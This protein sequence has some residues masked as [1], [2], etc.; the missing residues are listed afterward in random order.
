M[1]VDCIHFF[2]IWC[3]VSQAGWR[4]RVDGG[5]VAAA[6]KAREEGLI[7]H[8]VVSSHLPG[9]ELA[10]VLKEAPF[11]GVTLGYCAINFPYR[12]KTLDV[13]SRMGL[14]VVTMNPLAGGL[15]PQNAKTFDFIRSE[16][17]ADVVQAAIRFNVSQPA[18]T[19][20]LVG[21]SNKAHVDQ[22]VDAVEH[23]EP[24]PPAHIDAIRQK[25]MTAYN[26]LCTGCG[27]CLP[28]PSGVNIPQLM[29]AYNHKLLREDH[30]D[31]HIVNRLNWH[32]SAKPAAARA[33]SL[34]GACEERCTQRLP[35]RERLKEIAALAEEK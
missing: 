24:Y 35:I 31:E 23:F 19:S 11:E 21:A 18:V 34:C 2:H 3:I 10:G 5:A 14:G 4:E 9:D 27:Y 16:H 17:D 6:L 1:G 29:D 12:Q 20:A 30:G 8:M 13:A 26:S 32:W 28:C 7:E 25:V 15:I 22:A 33:C